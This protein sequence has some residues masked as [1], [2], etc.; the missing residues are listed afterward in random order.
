MANMAITTVQQEIINS[1]SERRGALDGRSNKHHRR[2]I[3]S[4]GLDHKKNRLS[5]AT[6]AK[7][8]LVSGDGVKFTVEYDVIVQSQHLK[9]LLT[10]A[11][12]DEDVALDMHSVDLREILRY[13]EYHS[14]SDSG[15]SKAPTKDIQEWDQNFITE[16]T[17]D[18]EQHL[19]LVVAA[20]RLTIGGLFR[21]LVRQLVAKLHNKT[22]EEIRKE[23]NIADDLSAEE[24]A[25][26]LETT[27]WLYPK[28]HK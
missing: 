13:C 22:S 27:T 3:Y 9:E 21:L 7:F 12:P 8:T 24:K 15:A 14:K 5:M 10:V 25:Q 26:V 18:Q 20:D 6:P 2:T 1:P 4:A 23:W 16:V 19:R 28:E 11:Q 17:K